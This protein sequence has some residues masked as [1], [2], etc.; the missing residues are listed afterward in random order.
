[1]GL[2]I[3]SYCIASD[4]EWCEMVY[5]ERMQKTLAGRAGDWLGRNCR[6]RGAVFLIACLS[7]LIAFTTSFS[8]TTLD[9][10]SMAWRFGISFAVGYVVY[11]TSIACWLLTVPQLEHNVLMRSASA[12][13]ETHDPGE[14]TQGWIEACT[15][16]HHVST[17]ADG[18]G[19][20]GV[21][22]A[23]IIL[24]MLFVIAYRVYFAKWHLGEL[25]VRSG[26]VSHRSIKHVA[27]GAWIVEPIRQTIWLAIF[28]TL[29]FALLGYCL[30][31]ELARI[32]MGR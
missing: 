2:P 18:R 11:T 3:E 21:V 10:R 29:Q 12:S 26:K 27:A 23:T 9:I 20:V 17:N 4:F 32:A 5:A 16:H 19:L 8:L 1:M 13:I 24:G 28:L 25:L 7:I 31:N 14:K 15:R 6:P 22:I 30:E